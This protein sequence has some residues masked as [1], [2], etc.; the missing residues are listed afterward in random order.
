MCARPAGDQVNLNPSMD[1]E[2]AHEALP[3]AEELLIQFL[4]AGVCCGVLQY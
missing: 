3:L 4:G 2:R 1:Q